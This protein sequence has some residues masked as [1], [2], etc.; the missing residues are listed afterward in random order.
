MAEQAPA[1]Y[2]VLDAVGN[3]RV[4]R[5]KP[6]VD[7]LLRRPWMKVSQLFVM[8]AAMIAFAS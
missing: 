6:L 1:A 3:M 2:G 5:M 7:V 4:E 8:G